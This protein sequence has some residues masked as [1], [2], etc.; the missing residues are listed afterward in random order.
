MFCRV[1]SDAEEDSIWN[2]QAGQ[3]STYGAKKGEMVGQ[4]HIGQRKGSRSDKHIR[5]RGRGQD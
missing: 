4:V 2:G 3:T 5:G 1:E